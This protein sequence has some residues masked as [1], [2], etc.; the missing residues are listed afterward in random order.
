[1]KNSVI[2]VVD[3][4][5]KIRKLLRRCFEGEGSS[6]FEAGDK[7]ATLTAIATRQIDLITLDLEMPRMDGII[8]KL[9]L[10]LQPSEIFRYA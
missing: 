2:L 10:W 1:M 7:A 6:V 3:D 8:Q 4:D 5:P 9:Q